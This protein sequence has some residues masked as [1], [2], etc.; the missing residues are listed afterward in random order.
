MLDSKIELAHCLISKELPCAHVK[1]LEPEFED[2]RPAK[3]FEI[4][5]EINKESLD[6]VTR[7]SLQ[8]EELYP[9]SEFVFVLWA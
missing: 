1:V 2:D 6:A 8:W 3:V 9:D 5:A 4:Y 7:I